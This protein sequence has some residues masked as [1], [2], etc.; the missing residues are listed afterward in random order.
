VLRITIEEQAK[1]IYGNSIEIK[2]DEL[3]IMVGDSE[4]VFPREL[5]TITKVEEV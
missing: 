2:G 3:I 5:V 4:N 1:P